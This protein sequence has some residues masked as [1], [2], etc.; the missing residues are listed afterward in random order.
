[1]V[2]TAQAAC[3]R[4][5][6]LSV[7]RNLRL[8]GSCRWFPTGLPS[9]LIG[10]SQNPWTRHCWTLASCVPRG[11]LLLVSCL[12]CSAHFAPA[13]SQP[14]C[15]LLQGQQTDKLPVSF[16][17]NT[18]VYSST[19][20]QSDI[21][22]KVTG[23]N[24][25]STS[26]S[27][28]CSSKCSTLN[29]ACSVLNR[30]WKKVFGFLGTIGSGGIACESGCAACC[31]ANCAVQA[32]CSMTGLLYHGHLRTLQDVT[33]MVATQ[34]DVAIPGQAQVQ[35]A[36]TALT[37][38]CTYTLPTFGGGDWHA[39]GSPRETWHMQSTLPVLHLRMQPTRAG[40]CCCPCPAVLVLYV[41]LR[42]GWWLKILRCCWSVINSTGG[43]GSSNQSDSLKAKQQQGKAKK[44]RGADGDEDGSGNE[45]VRCVCCA[46]QSA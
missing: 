43:G 6:V 8:L 24:T 3:I 46:D 33:A 26:S 11:S 12:A 25:P 19:P 5:L 13:S 28:T 14:M 38:Y 21:S 1:M 42:H 34:A 36:S 4:H 30:C 9:T 40:L 16:L 37:T 31:A 20:T 44:S 39:G 15:L 41:G 22:D 29:I 10:A 17:T 35:Q 45:E 27:D 18:T 7:H 32:V 23:A 2:L